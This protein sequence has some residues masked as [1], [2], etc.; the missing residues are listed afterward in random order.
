MACA[1]KTGQRT[2][3]QLVDKYRNNDITYSFDFAPLL[4][5]TWKE[6]D[7]SALIVHMDELGVEDS[8]KLSYATV[9][10]EHVIRFTTRIREES[11]LFKKHLYQLNVG[12]FVE[13][14][15]PEGDFR[16][17]RDGRPV[18]LLSNGVG[19]AAI[20]SLVEAFKRDSSGVDVMTQINVDGSGAIYKEEMETFASKDSRFNSIYAPN[21]KAFYDVLDEAV[22]DVMFLSGMMPYYYVV[23]SD[24][25]VEDTIQYLTASGFDGRDIITDASG[26]GCGGAKIREV[27]ADGKVNFTRPLKLKKPVSPI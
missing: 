13:V 16:L 5:M 15:A 18:V 7:S 12:D 26:C 21:R 23:G 6:G 17:I 10:K 27:K 8:R 1:C 19:I 11:S 25:F 2:L 20:R 4:P 14:T 3:L 9:P 24:S 22:R